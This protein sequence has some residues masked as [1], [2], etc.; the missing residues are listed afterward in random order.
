MMLSARN[1]DSQ[2]VP[3]EQQLPN[4]NM[5]LLDPNV[6]QRKLVSMHYTIFACMYNIIVM[7]FLHFVVCVHKINVY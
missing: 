5:H 3:A 7:L 1:D 6:V 4:T 2:T